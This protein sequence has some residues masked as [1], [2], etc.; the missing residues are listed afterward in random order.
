MLNT[1]PTAIEKKI[2]E[3]YT[4]KEIKIELKYFTLKM[5]T[6]YKEGNNAENKGQKIY[7]IFRKQIAKWWKWS[8]CLLVILW[9]VCGLKFWMKRLRFAE[10]EWGDKI[11]Q[12][13]VELYTVY[14]KLILDPKTNTGWKRKDRRYFM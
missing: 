2:A 14:K 6:K 9:N 11:K 7:M 5:S 4:Q 1:I 12:N 3:E 10:W 8:L 13:M